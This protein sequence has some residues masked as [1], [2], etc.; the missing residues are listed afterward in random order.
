M[1]V[2]DKLISTSQSAF[3]PGRFI[4]DGAVTLH[5]S[6]HELHRSNKDAIVLKLDF[7]KAY[8]NIK[9]PFLQ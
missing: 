2:A 3:L 7:E 9:W 8:D 4:L 5:E 1:N 6:L